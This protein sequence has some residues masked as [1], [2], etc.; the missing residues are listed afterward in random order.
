[1][2]RIK[3]VV[4]LL[5]FSLLILC[6]CG[7][8]SSSDTDTDMRL[9]S[10]EGEANGNSSQSSYAYDSL[11][12][13]TSLY[14]KSVMSD[15]GLD[16]GMMLS[17]AE[18]GSEYRMKYD[19]NGNISQ[20]QL[21]SEIFEE[22]E[23]ISSVLYTQYDYTY[24]E[25]TLTESVESRFDIFDS[26]EYQKNSYDYDDA[27]N[28]ITIQVYRS[29]GDNK[30]FITTPSQVITMTYDVNKNLIQVENKYAND[31]NPYG[32]T[33]VMTYNSDNQMVKHERYDDVELD[34]NDSLTVDNTYELVYGTIA[35]TVTVT[36][37][38]DALDST[39]FCFL[40]KDIGYLNPTAGNS[41]RRVAKTKAVRRMVSS[42]APL[43]PSKLMQLL[44]VSVSY[45]NYREPV[46]LLATQ[47]LIIE[48]TSL[49]T[50]DSP[51]ETTYFDT[52]LDENGYPQTM[53]FYE[54]MTTVDIDIN[55]T[56]E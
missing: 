23:L 17:S 28:L 1:M 55:F 16:K 22:G 26:T 40:G 43:I 32:N 14:T 52:I 41:I 12:R 42:G 39:V 21:W 18:M 6:A 36:D 29:E 44:S 50:G 4:V 7:G 27:G 9:I 37:T 56:W 3:S 10:A 30:A 48:S 8:C 2:L 54:P 19:D 25:N 45:D 31:P 24:V 49:Y 35:N 51:T 53:M 20:V 15:L 47:E 34:I 46:E 11:D 33:Y 38:A 13:L 5:L